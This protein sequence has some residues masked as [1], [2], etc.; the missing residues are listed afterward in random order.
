LTELHNVGC[1]PCGEFLRWQRLTDEDTER[2]LGICPGCGAMRGFLPDE[3][4]RQIDDP[5]TTFLGQPDPSPS[6][7]PWMRA[8]RASAGWPWFAR[9]SHQRSPCDH[10]S[11]P[12]VL[13]LEYPPAA[14]TGVC[15]TLCLACGA[16]GLLEGRLLSGRLACGPPVDA[17]VPRGHPTTASVIHANATALSGPSQR[18]R[19]GRIIVNVIGYTS[20]DGRAGRVGARV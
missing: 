3:P 11:A 16:V 14:F 10:C 6:R 13:T 8:F 20:L 19:G 9:W 4:T 5:L 1:E 7:P 17:A 2:W 15:G 12:T 18:W